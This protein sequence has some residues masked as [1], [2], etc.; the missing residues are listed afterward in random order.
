MPTMKDVAKEAGVSLG[1]V[2]NVLNNC[3]SVTKENKAKVDAAIKRLGYRPNSAA[4]TLKT[5]A[6]Q[7]IGLIIPDINNP[8]YPEVSRGAEDVAM[9]NGYTLLLCNSDRNVEKERRYIDFLI[10]KKTDGIILVKPHISK[11]EIIEIQNHCHIVLVDAPDEGD[12]LCDCIDVDDFLGSMA[13]MNILCEHGHKRIAFIGGYE[14]KSGNSRHEAYVRCLKDNRI[15]IDYA[16]IKKGAYDWHSGYTCMIELLRI[17]D[18]P[19]AVFAAN[20]LMAIGAIKA[21]REK[22]LTVPRDIS[23]FGYD[24]INM[25]NLCQPALTTVRQPKYEIG[26]ISAEMLILDRIIPSASGEKKGFRNVILKPEILYRESVAICK[27]WN[28]TVR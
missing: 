26:S 7:S 14:S 16:L 4:R 27:D 12:M 13:A 10:E 11:A 9:K 23:V 1:T 3:M 17:P 20:D 25:A 2:S 19:T 22:G 21:I 5:N 28:E 18:M 8:F 6:S 24:D 15:E